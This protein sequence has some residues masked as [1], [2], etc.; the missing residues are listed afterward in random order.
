M[1]EIIVVKDYTNENLKFKTIS[2][3]IIYKSMLGT[4]RSSTSI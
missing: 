2:I 1:N 4:L 3:S